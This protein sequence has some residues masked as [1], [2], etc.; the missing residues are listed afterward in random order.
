MKLISSDGAITIETAAGHCEPVTCLALSPDGNYLVT[1]SQDTTLILWRIHRAPVSH[2]SN[3]SE[4]S[5]SAATT[6]FTNSPHSCSDSS[7]IVDTSR[8]PRIEGPL[9]VLRG[10]LK[11]IVCCCVDSDTGIVV[12]CSQS[13]GVLLH[14][15]RGQLIRNLED[16]EA[17][18]VRLSSEGVVM[19]WNKSKQTLST[20]TINGI[21]IATAILSFSGS[22][23]CMEVSVDGES[24]LICTTSCSVDKDAEYQSTSD[25]K[26]IE[27]DNLKV[28]D[29]TLPSQESFVNQLADEVPSICFL[30]LHTLKV[31]GNASKKMHVFFI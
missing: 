31:R 24:A 16:V 20:F 14:S 26:E 29:V 9:Q 2:L 5:T 28:N 25:S 27:S 12:S 3:I 21:P 10:H 11:A 23:S 18:A 8:R 13:S 6:T 15:I 19:T 1:G 7:S 22:I 4:S 17:D 30:N